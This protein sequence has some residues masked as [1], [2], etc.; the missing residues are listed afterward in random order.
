M[1]SKPP[2]NPYDTR[3]GTPA[4]TPGKKELSPYRCIVIGVSA[5]GMDA[6]SMII[7]SIPQEFPV[8]M[9]I[10]QHISPYSDNYITRYLDSI[11]Q[12]KIKELDEKEKI[13]PGV[14]YTAPPNYHVL[15]EDDE[16][17]SLSVEDRVNYA[18]PSIDV[19]FESAAD[20][21]G[22]KLIGMILTGANNDGSIGLR[23]IKEVG[24]IAIVQDPATAEVDG[25]PRA[26]IAAT[27]VD[28]IL[29]LHQIPSLLIKLVS[30]NPPT[31]IESK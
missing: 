8:P 28:Y 4:R 7:P 16:T 1:K 10:I 27:P 13:V 26:A 30:Q 6:L 20:V 15:I 21:Y 12:L 9:I 2:T 23:R 29:P 17:F 14:V 25:M 18:R 24:G 22:S 3:L 19:L 11:S 31:R 5:G